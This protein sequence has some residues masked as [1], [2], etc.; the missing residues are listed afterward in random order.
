MN[1]FLAGEH[2]LLRP[3]EM[4]DLEAFAG[5]FMDRE[6]TRYSM[7]VWLFPWSRYETE[8]WLK[9]TLLDKETLSLGVVEKEGGSLIGY[10]GIAS[11]SLVNRSGEYYIFLGAKESWGKGYGT[12]VTRLIVDYGFASLNLHR[13]MLTV[14]E[15]N[16]AGVRAYTRVGFQ[17]EG[18]LR[19]ACYRDGAYHDKLVM[20]IFR[21]SWEANRAAQANGEART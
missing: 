20:A 16:I 18:V 7:G 12:E 14:S 6:A 11:I 1:A 19:D 10:A 3:L 17:Q 4:D 5:W 15:S 8:Q 2:I 9:R 13:I 21:P